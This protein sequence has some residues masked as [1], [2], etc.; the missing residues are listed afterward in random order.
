MEL[1]QEKSVHQ[2]LMD[3]AYDKWRNNKNWDY[4]DF[5][6]EL[7]IKH[8]LAVLTGNL[9]YQVENGGFSQWYFNDYSSEAQKL[10]TLLSFY[11]EEPVIAEV[12]QLVEKAV[13]IIDNYEIEIVRVRSQWDYDDEEIEELEN[14]MKDKLDEL[15]DKYYEIND[16][17]MKVMEKILSN[18]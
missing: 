10:L 9:N 5:V 17:F 12:I 8:A 15:D 16:E 18:M 14:K 13:R 7:G 11:K 3:E 1:K 4:N 6:S 2:Q